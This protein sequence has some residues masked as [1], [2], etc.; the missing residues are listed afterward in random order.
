MARASV[1]F[2]VDAGAD[3]GLGHLQRCL[4][5]ALAFRHIGTECIFLTKTEPLAHDRIRRFGFEA[6]PLEALELWGN[7]D[8]TTTVEL[9]SKRSCNTI[10]VD[11][12][13]VRPDYLG[14]LRNAGIL[15]CAL[16]DLAPFAFPIQIV[17][18]GDVHACHL[19]YESSS[20]DTIYILGPAY[21]L[22][23]REF[24]QTPPYIVRSPVKKVLVTLGGADTYNL[25][26]RIL[27]ELD[28]LCHDIVVTA[29]IGPFFDNLLDIEC[30]A[31][32]AK[33]R[34]QLIHSPD[35]IRDL[36]LE[37]D[38]AISAGGQTLYELACVGCPAV[39]F[40]AAPNQE[41]QLQAFIDTGSVRYAGDIDTDNLVAAIHNEVSTL[42]DDEGTR[43][44]MSAAGRR[45][46]DG[47]GA[48]RVADMIMRE[49]N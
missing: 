9:A 15:V 10:I 4:S 33:D 25:M 24:W 34:I 35:S 39:V 14:S 13:S 38:L 46:I 16:D 18:N 7:D 5:L 32:Q 31:L 19:H 29:I 40:T 45:L 36:I 1:L 49:L 43:A 28:V 3:I 22:L 42:L 23:R 41:K 20:G 8:F 2:R 37:A 27:G 6:Y 21:A 47:Q 44:V 30:T 26:P 17:V 12:Y 11:S 48:L